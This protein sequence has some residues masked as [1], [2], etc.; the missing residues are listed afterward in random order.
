[1]AKKVTKKVQATKKKT[2]KKPRAASAKARPMSDILAVSETLV[3][4]RAY[5]ISLARKGP[6]DPV[7]DWFQAERELQA[8]SRT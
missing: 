3:R 4:E 2:A 6:S 5:E 7:A 1:M 8:E